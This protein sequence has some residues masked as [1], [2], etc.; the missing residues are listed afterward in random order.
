MTVSGRNC[1]S[2][3]RAVE[4]AARSRPAHHPKSPRVGLPT[5]RPTRTRA[6]DELGGC[7]EAGGNRRWALSGLGPGVEGADLSLSAGAGRRAGLAGRTAVRG[8]EPTRRLRPQLADPGW[9]GAWRE[10]FSALSTSQ[11]ASRILN[12]GSN[13]FLSL[14]AIVD[15]DGAQVGGD[16]FYL[17]FSKDG[18][19]GM[20]VSVVMDAVPPTGGFVNDATSIS[21]ARRRRRS[22]ARRGFRSMPRTSEPRPSWRASRGRRC[23]SA[24]GSPGTTSS[25]S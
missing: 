5:G 12:D 14:Q 3:N 11:V 17:G 2:E 23:S 16:G 24:P 9:T 20:F 10:D 7:Y 13:L 19:T 6:V 8:D 22:I 4:L 25:P 21:S 15:P 1:D 18:T